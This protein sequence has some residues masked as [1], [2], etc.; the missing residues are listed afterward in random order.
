MDPDL[1]IRARAVGKKFCRS[2]GR[3][4][5]YGLADMGQELFGV[6]IDRRRLRNGEYWAVE[7][8]DFDL[9]RGE[10][11]G[12]IGHNG[13]GKSTLLKL[14]AGVLSPDHGQIL[15]RGRVST[16]LEIGAGFHPMLSGREN[17]Y[18]NGA[19]LGMRRREIDTRFDE[20]VDFAGIEDFLDSPVKHYSSG[21]YM[22]LGFSI[23]AHTQ[24][25][26]L[27]IDEALA[28]GDAAFRSKC[29]NRIADLKAQ[30]AAILFVSH[31]EIDM[32][33]VSDRCLLLT[34]DP[35]GELGHPG[36]MLQRY[37]QARADS[38][39]RQHRESVPGNDFAAGCRISNV[40]IETPGADGHAVSGGRCRIV[41]EV[42]CDFAVADVA[43][44]LRWWNSDEQLVA[45]LDR[46]NIRGRIDLTAGT[47]R[48]CFELAELNLTPDHYRLAGGFL[49]DGSILAWSFELDRVTIEPSSSCPT[50][51]IVLL[52]G[53][54]SI[55]DESHNSYRVGEG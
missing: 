52:H 16:L 44:E 22:R 50:V 46:S 54:V 45:V 41:L 23:A 26:V 29:L 13:A 43:L 38:Y 4:M 31:S 39:H 32:A 51:G 27:L 12:V 1:R 10:C 36:A 3:S 14:V 37:R 11:L 19:I 20:I 42:A 49:K 30:G 53:V 55:E 6:R 40:A 34:G 15:V 28:V 35:G 48:V 7:D 25:D 17:I 24:P 2:L 33:R 47:Q 21:M 5:M 8:I 9:G 18:V